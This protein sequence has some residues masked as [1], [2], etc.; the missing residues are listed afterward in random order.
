MISVSETLIGG[1]TRVDPSGVPSVTRMRT[2]TD[3]LLFGG[4]A[5]RLLAE[6]KA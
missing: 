3:T 1:T 6:S 4:A 5:R 2:S